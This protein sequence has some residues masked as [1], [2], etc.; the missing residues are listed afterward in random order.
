[1]RAAT[2]A[3]M[4]SLSSRRTAPAHAKA[5]LAALSAQ[6]SAVLENAGCANIDRVAAAAGHRRE[7]LSERL[8]MQ[9]TDADAVR[10]SLRAAAEQAEDIGT[11]VRG[12]SVGR[13]ASV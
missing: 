7:H 1:M 9:L 10:N 13:N 3:P 11:G 2:Y 5:A 4:I 12:T 8:V 6:Y